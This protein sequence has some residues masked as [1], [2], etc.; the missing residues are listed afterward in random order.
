MHLRPRNFV[1]FIA[2]VVAASTLVAAENSKQTATAPPA[3]STDTAS[4]KQKPKPTTPRDRRAAR[5]AATKAKKEADRTAWLAKLKERNVE[6]WPENE[7][8]DEHDAALKKSREM[9]NEVL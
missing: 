6:P 3:E 8:D 9:A 7:T 1:A 2:L 4:P 5:D